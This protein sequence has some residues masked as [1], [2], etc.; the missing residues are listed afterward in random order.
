[1]KKIGM[2]SLGCP[3]NTVDTELV[4]GDLLENGYEITSHQEEADIIIINT[5][6]FIEAS[7]RESIDAILEMAALKSEGR[8]KKLVVTGCLSERY[9]DELLKEIPEIDH[10][11]GVNQYPQLKHILKITSDSSGRTASRHLET[12]SRTSIHHISSRWKRS[13]E[14]R[15]RTIWY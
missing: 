15:R 8:C 7:K 4:L 14:F 9:N 1:M 13:C 3:K 2:V 12:S 11:L 5:C 6:G 10:M